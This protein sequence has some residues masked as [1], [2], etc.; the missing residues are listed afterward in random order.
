MQSEVHYK[1]YFHFILLLLIVSICY[2]NTLDGEW[3]LDDIPNIVENGNVHLH[4][5]SWDE[6][7]R[8]FNGPI[9]GGMLARPIAYFSFA[10]NY[11]FSAL[12][13][14]GYH[15]FNIAIHIITSFIIYLVC[16]EI[17]RF[18]QKKN[19]ATDFLYFSRQDIALFA[20][21]L[22]AIHPIQTQG[23]TYIV[24][25]MASMAGM[26][27][28]LALYCYLKFRHSTA[29]KNKP[30]YLILVIFFWIL[31]ILT[32][33][34][35]VMFPF[36][37]LLY[38]LAFVMQAG[39]RKKNALIALGVSI[40]IV[41]LLTYLLTGGKIFEAIVNPYEIR[42]FTLWQRLITEPIILFRYLFLIIC[43]LENFL[44]V[45]PD[46]IASK[47][48]LQ[49]PLTFVANFGVIVL[50][51]ICW[52]YIQKFPVL[53]FSLLFFFVNHL[54]E[55]SILGLELYFEQR[56]Y[57]PSIFLY[58][59]LSYYALKLCDYYA[60][61]AKSAMLWLLVFTL[62][63]VLVSE[64]N[65]TFLRNET[66]RTTVSLLSD[67][68]DKAPLNIRAR[69]S[70]GAAYI[71]QN[72]L[73]KAQYHLSY[74]G[75]LYGENPG[76]YQKNWAALLYYN[77]GILALRKS[78][79]KKAI[80]FLKK[81]IKLGP[82]ATGW[83]SYFNLGVLYFNERDLVNAEFMLK[84]ALH[85]G[86]SLPDIYNVLGRI[87]YAEDKLDESVNVFRDGLEKEPTVEL[88]L[89]LV[90]A[91]F[92]KG[93]VK[94]AKQELLSIPYNKEDSVY[95]LYRAI[96]FSDEDELE[97]SLSKVA[98]NIYS[99]NIKYNDWLHRVQENNFAGI[100][101]PD[102]SSLEGKLNQKYLN[103][104][105]QV[106]ENINSKMRAGMNCDES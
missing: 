39:Q 54:V 52:R 94:G 73:G 55:S 13:T 58:F 8:S 91:L 92:K 62:T 72:M 43:P 37:L 77:Q 45:E 83:N 18:Y 59:A 1:H 28:M 80:Y 26:F 57:L 19:T 76:R 56:N 71:R 7:R 82:T 23:V 34:Q 53:C 27:Y 98:Y 11:Y 24:Q 29:T 30:V 22:W 106:K 16:L 64:G 102:V 21:V 78:E 48:L 88:K 93:N 32:K 105:M 74:A 35:V 86:K 60:R 90:S 97:K 6:L 49:P 103:L 81:S 68:I 42:P 89:N 4:S 65:A 95:L 25:R 47:S 79:K 69:M 36:V 70:L 31:G 100:I 67:T 41:V 2:A 96:L 101:Y 9:G 75:K 99:S 38:E 61:Q 40:V 5:L 84:K 44:V 63:V 50:I 46:F 17:L 10:L 51:L 104:L 66:W 33:E 20:A 85:Y 15:I 87:L 12:D 14:T 3:H